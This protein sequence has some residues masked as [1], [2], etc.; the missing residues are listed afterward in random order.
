V[1]RWRIGPLAGIVIAALALL[2]ALPAAA[3]AAGT[4]QAT[5]RVAH[6]SP[7]ASYVDVYAV[8]LNR[9][10]MFPNVFYKAVSAYWKVSAG[11]FTYEVR[12]AGTP[13]SAPPEI[14][15]S[16]TRRAGGVYTVAAVGKLG[17]L[18]AVLLEDDMSAARPG[19]A[20]VRFLDTAVDRPAVDVTAG[21]RVLAS[22][23][24]FGVP[25]GYVQL[26]PGSYRLAAR[27]SSGAGA[28]ASGQLT[29]GAGTLTSV[30]LL[31]GGRAPLELF[32]FGDAAAARVAPTGAVRTGGGGTAPTGPPPA[33]ALLAAAV[34]AAAAALALAGT[35]ATRRSP[36][37]R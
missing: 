27:A 16:A 30:A 19:G 2:P 8:T 17:H 11:P 6:F 5:V 31:G 15:L 33:A 26:S 13:A 35:T 4:G 34:L 32:S 36:S 10:Q 29:V 12:P 3:G 28:L 14:R 24:A 20:K 22:N 18:S 21:G 37:A 1:A 25:T 9:T 23:A 7:D